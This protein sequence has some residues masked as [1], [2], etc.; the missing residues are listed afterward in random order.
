MVTD[1]DTPVDDGGGNPIFALP[2]GFVRTQTVDFS[3][4][5]HYATF[6]TDATGAYQGWFI[7]EP[8]GGGRF[9]PGKFVFMRI[10]MNDGGTGTNVEARVTSADSVRIVKLATTATDSTGTGLRASS[11]VPARDFIFAYDNTAGTGRPISGTFVENDGS[12]NTTTNAYSVF[13]AASVDT[14]PGAFGMVLPNL[15]PS[16]VRRFD[17]RDQATGTLSNSITDSDGKWPSG[18]QTANPTG[19]PIAIAIAASDLTTL[20]V[21]VDQPVQVERRFML[22]QNRPNP[23]RQTTAIRFSVAESGVAT[24]VIY[25]VLGRVAATPFNGLAVPGQEYVVTVD[26]S[27]LRSGVYWYRLTS[28][29]QTATMKMVLLR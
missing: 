3:T 25:D 22:Y 10:N 27:R 6:T 21:G 9:L 2:S 15:L 4:A 14:F 28:G 11:S 8:T 5:G 23:G 1:A 24:L 26:G 12:P 17:W 29:N 16:G 20:V 18:A 13:Y 19:G 7:I